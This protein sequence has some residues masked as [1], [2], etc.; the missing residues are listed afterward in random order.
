MATPGDQATELR[1]LSW[2]RASAGVTEGETLRREHIDPYSMAAAETLLRTQIDA[3]DHVVI[4]ITCMTKPHVLAAAAVLVGRPRDSWRVAYTIPE[5]YGDLNSRRSTRG[6]VD[7]LLLPLGPDPSLSNEGLSLGLMLLGHEAERSLISFEQIEPSAGIAVLFRRADRPDL[8]RVTRHRNRLLLQRLQRLRMPI[9]KRLRDE[10]LDF[11]VL[12]EVLEI[13]MHDLVPGVARIV[14][15]L[16][17]PARRVGAPVVLY[18]FGP[19]MAIFLA[20]LLLWRY[21]PEGSWA[22]YPIAST[23]PL[24]Y[25]DGV[26]S[27]DFLSGDEIPI[28]DDVG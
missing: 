17:G 22:V 28:L 4:D 16:V 8:E 9:G 21:Y 27:T 18:P 23:H 15:S 11:P 20:A 5:T 7:T 3:V 1:E 13:P 19:K 2:T 24:D 10:T 6:W 12:W 25:S 26:L 14:G